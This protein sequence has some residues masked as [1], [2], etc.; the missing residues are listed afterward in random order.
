LQQI[1]RAV[2]HAAEGRVSGPV[3]A[4]RVRASGLVAPAAVQLSIFGPAA[5]PETGQRELEHAIESIREKF[6]ARSVTTA[7]TLVRSRRDR[8]LAESLL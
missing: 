2:I 8:M 3:S 1:T 6:G 4:I 5:Q 7:N